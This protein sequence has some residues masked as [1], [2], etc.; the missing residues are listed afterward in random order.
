[1]VDDHDGGT[2]PPALQDKGV[3]ASPPHTAIVSIC[4]RGSDRKPAPKTRQRGHLLDRIV[5]ML[6]EQQAWPKVDAIQLP[7]GFFRIPSPI[8]ANGSD[9]RRS[10]LSETRAGRACAAASQR[11]AI[12]WPGIALITGIDSDRLSK[13]IGG[14]QMNVA[15]Q[16]GVVTALGRKAFPV[17]GDTDGNQPVYW[18]APSDADD[19]DRILT[20]R[21]GRRALLLSCY[22]AFAVRGLVKPHYA[23]LTAIR[24][25]L[26]EYGD[27]R[28]PTMLER[29]ALLDRWLSFLAIQNPNLG[30]IAIHRF[31]RPGQD[32]YWQRHG[33]AAASAALNG[34]PIIAAAHIRS[35]LPEP[36]SM[37]LAAADVPD[38]HLDLGTYRPAHRL[39]AHDSLTLRDDQGEPI[40][41]LRLF[42]SH[43]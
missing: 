42:K 21:T 12:R 16:D 17:S 6:L 7:G 2:L 29:R 5:S 18:V 35:R 22:D 41:L 24:L 3:E 39:A 43:Y 27:L 15:W 8:G 13:Q 40:A 37:T 20:L 26:D 14:D 34:H 32:G 1:M 36:H 38:F 4:I 31:A 33:I 11:L 30:L 25:I 10:I 23:S 28:R 9:Q 19:A